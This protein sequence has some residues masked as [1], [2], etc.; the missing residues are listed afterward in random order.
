MNNN[1]NALQ[2]QQQGISSSST[3]TFL[4]PASTIIE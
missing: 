3:A 1:S 2:L 4:A